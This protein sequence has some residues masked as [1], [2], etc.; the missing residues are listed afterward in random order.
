MN[1]KIEENVL[2]AI[3]GRG[4]TQKE[5]YEKLS[6]SPNG[7]RE[8]LKRRSMTVQNLIKIAQ[9]LEVEPQFFFTEGT[10]TDNV[11][12]DAKAKYV[13]Q[14]NGNGSNHAI[15]DENKSLKDEVDFLRKQVEMQVKIIENLTKK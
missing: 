10:N 11:V 12:K 2:S 7:W 5:V 4:I 9:I 14:Q 13:V 8:M 1:Y 6:F 3:G 15:I